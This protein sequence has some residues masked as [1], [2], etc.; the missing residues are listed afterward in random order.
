MLGDAA[1]LRSARLSPAWLR[2]ELTTT[3][4]PN[5]SLARYRDLTPTV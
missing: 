4:E 2:D 1:K 3:P 5:K